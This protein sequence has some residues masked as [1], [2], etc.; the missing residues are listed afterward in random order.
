MKYSVQH[1][2]A[3][4]SRVRVV[5]EKAYGAYEERLSDYKPKL[6]WEAD[7]RATI[8][9]TVM[10]QK[11]DAAVE[12]DDDEL[13]IDGKVPFLFKPFQKKIEDVLGREMDK[14]LDKARKG[15]V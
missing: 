3:D 7:D 9:F 8:A 11:I 15:E 10:S 6:H 5:V 4:R 2:L 14:W 12:F 1:G 13:R